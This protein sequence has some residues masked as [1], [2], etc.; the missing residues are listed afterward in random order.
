ML[1][2]PAC[3]DIMSPASPRATQRYAGSSSYELGVESVATQAGDLFAVAHLPAV[4][5]TALSP[6]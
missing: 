3:A 6:L 4:T 5:A 1:A 2:E